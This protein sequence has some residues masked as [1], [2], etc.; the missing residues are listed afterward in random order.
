[1]IFNDISLIDRTYQRMFFF[2][3]SSLHITEQVSFNKWITEQNR[4]YDEWVDYWKERLPDLTNQVY[5]HY[6]TESIDPVRGAK[7][8]QEVSG[9]NFTPIV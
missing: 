1:M 5:Y 3:L 7:W 9:V 6:Y 4:T 2:K 8:L